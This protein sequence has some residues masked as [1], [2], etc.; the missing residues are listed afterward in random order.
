MIVVLIDLIYCESIFASDAL[1]VSICK[2]TIDRFSD[3]DNAQ[4]EVSNTEIVA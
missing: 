2:S 1:V 3:V 4:D